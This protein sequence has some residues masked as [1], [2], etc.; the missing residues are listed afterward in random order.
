[1]EGSCRRGASRKTSRA[2][3]L[4]AL[5]NDPSVGAGLVMVRPRRYADAINRAA[6]FKEEHP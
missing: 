1:M 4:A 2:A 6:S 3:I 5:Q